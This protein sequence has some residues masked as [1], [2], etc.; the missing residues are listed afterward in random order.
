MCFSRFAYCNKQSQ[1]E[2]PNMLEERLKSLEEAVR[3]LT[4]AMHG[5][6]ADK[7]DAAPKSRR[8]KAD[9][10]DDE[11]K[12]RRGKD[13]DD[14]PKSRR[15]K[16]A[17]DEPKSRRSKSDDA[18]DEPKSRRSKSDDA[19]GSSDITLDDV[20]K[21]YAD[22]LGPDDGKN[23]DDNADFVEAVLNELGADKISKIEEEDFAKAMHWLKLKKKNPKAKVDFDDVPE[24]GRK[25]RREV[26]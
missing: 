5:G 25:R 2:N 19:K 6:K 9:D 14:E 24:E 20:R 8:S 16:D 11:P 22:F 15:G 17:D 4:A 18:D 10:A 21:A 13:A 7:A 1:Q 23:Y 12:S 3:E 26:D